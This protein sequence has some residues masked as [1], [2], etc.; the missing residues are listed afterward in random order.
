MAI[1][2]SGKSTTLTAQSANARLCIVR[3]VPGITTSIN[4]QQPKKEPY[5][6]TVKLF[7]NLTESSSSQ[8]LNIK[9]SSSTTVVFVADDDSKT[10]LVIDVQPKQLSRTNRILGG[11]VMR[12]CKFPQDIKANQ[13][14]STNPSGNG[15]G[16]L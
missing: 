14:K 15:F 3:T 9:L 5:G 11:I 13:S 6:I 16:N 2:L 10:T 7:G 8:E 1:T 12:P 4:E